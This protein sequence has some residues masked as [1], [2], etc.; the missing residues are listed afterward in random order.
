[1]WAAALAVSLA[2]WGPP[3]CDVQYRVAALDDALGR[4][5]WGGEVCLVEIDARRWKW[6]EL[7]YA[8]L[9][10]TGHTRAYR[11]PVGVLIRDEETGK[12][13]IDYTHSPDPLSVMYPALKRP[14]DACRGKRPARYRRGSVIRLDVQ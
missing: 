8:M 3:P 12:V 5:T 9:H 13:W 11:D 4:A 14:A 2:F 7:C 6:W 10:E 1:V